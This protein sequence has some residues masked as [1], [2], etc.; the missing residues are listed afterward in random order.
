[1]RNAGT[2]ETAWCL[3]ATLVQVG[4]VAPWLVFATG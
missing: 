2:V 4:D 3:A 1:M